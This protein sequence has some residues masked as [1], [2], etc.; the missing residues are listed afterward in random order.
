MKGTRLS[1]LVFRTYEYIRPETDEELHQLFAQVGPV[2]SAKII[3]D[4]ATG[5][6]KGFG[7]VEM[8]NESDVAKAI[9]SNLNRGPHAL[10][11]SRRVPGRRDV[12]TSR[13][14]WP[15]P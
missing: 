15:S 13:A 11:C 4:R 1:D 5:R 10:A 2:V 14:G 3:I 8:E 12:P 6:S 9:V 7:F